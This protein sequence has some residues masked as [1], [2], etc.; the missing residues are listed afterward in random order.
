MTHAGE[1]IRKAVIT[2][3][4]K[5]KIL[6]DKLEVSRQTL[7]NLYESVDIDLAMIIRIGAILN[8]PLDELL[9]RPE[10]RNDPRMSIAAEPSKEDLK[11]EIDYW[12]TR[13]IALLESITEILT[14]REKK[15]LKPG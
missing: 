3:G 7:Y 13:Y 12:K 15:Q 11:A 14:A 4:I 2:H 9:Q 5:H 10:Y 6:A 8:D 1:I